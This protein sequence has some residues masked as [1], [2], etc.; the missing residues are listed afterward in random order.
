MQDLALCFVGPALMVAGR[1]WLVLRR[2]TDLPHRAVAA[3]IGAGVAARSA[4]ALASGDRPEFETTWS[5]VGPVLAVVTFNAAWL[6]WHVTA[7]FDLVQRNAT[8]RLAEHA[9]YLV[10]GVWFWLQVAGPRRPGRWQPPLRRLLLLTATTAAGTVLGMVLV[11]G[12]H[13]AYPGYANSLHHVLTVLDDQQ[14]SGAVLWMGM[15]PPL[16]IAAVVLLNRWLSDED[17]DAPADLGRLLRRRT[18]GWPARSGL[19]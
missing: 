8:A 11:F 2:L 16:V 13:V 6:G 19:R 9:C 4:L 10:V 1:P 17:A 3:R 15:M 12:A 5:R 14:L 18:S 7:P